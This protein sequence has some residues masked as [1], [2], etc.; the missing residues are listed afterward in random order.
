MYLQ[1]PRY[2]V[3]YRFADD[4]STSCQATETHVLNWVKLLHLRLTTCTVQLVATHCDLLGGDDEGKKDLLRAVE[5]EFRKLHNQWMDDRREDGAETGQMMV[6]EGVIAVACCL[7][8]EDDNRDRGLARIRNN[9]F[10]TTANRSYI[11]QSWVEA[12]GELIEIGGQ[13]DQ[14]GDS[15]EVA[16]PLLRA[17][18]MRD[19]IH[20]KFLARVEALDQN[21][22]V[23]GLSKEAIHAAMEGALELR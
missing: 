11:P 1:A 6:S 2:S 22:P 3:S 23:R 18:A 14:A 5:E 19:E 15:E 20:E 16:G 21:N 9:V 8:S 4:C 7:P 10:K 17:W 13:P 12:K